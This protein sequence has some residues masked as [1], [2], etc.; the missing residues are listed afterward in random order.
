MAPARGKPRAPGSREPSRRAASRPFGLRSLAHSS[1]DGARFASL[2]VRLKRVLLGAN[3]E[4]CHGQ[5]A[6]N[7]R[8]DRQRI[9]SHRQCRRHFSVFAH[10]AGGGGV[11]TGTSCVACEGE[12]FQRAFRWDGSGAATPVSSWSNRTRRAEGA[13]I[14][15]TG[16]VLE[17]PVTRVP[18]W[19]K[20]LW[21][22]L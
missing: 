9:G 15:S 5:F 17:E 1:E 6:G 20:P 22:G 13:G 19:P 12:V 21:S 4:P 7:Y 10:D 2:F 14:K 8:Q 11:R 3:T 18:V 16:I